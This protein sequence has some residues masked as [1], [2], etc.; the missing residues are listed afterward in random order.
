MIFFTLISILFPLF[1]IIIQ[2]SD[3]P[4]QLFYIDLDQLAQYT[5]I[6]DP[7]IT[8]VL[9]HIKSIKSSYMSGQNIFATH[10]SEI[11]FI[12]NMVQTHYTQLVQYLPP[13]Y[14]Y[15]TDQLYDLSFHYQTIKKYL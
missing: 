13:Q 6:I 12:L 5:D 2:A 14:K 11:V 7:Q 8:Q 10:E 15:F 4:K 3:D 1:S 9:E